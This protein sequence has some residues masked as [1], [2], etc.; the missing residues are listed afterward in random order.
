MAC[1]ADR[2][3][4]VLGQLWEQEDVGDVGIECLLEQRRRFARG[5]EDDRSLRV[6]ADGGQLVG[7]QRGAARRVQDGLEM[8]AGECARTFA[9]LFGSPDELDLAV[10]P[11]G[12]PSARGAL[13]S[14][15]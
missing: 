12:L 11:E 6:L 8:T 4:D 10:S 7:G 5:D 2:E 1:L 3:D 14:Y 15:R 9:D 13:R